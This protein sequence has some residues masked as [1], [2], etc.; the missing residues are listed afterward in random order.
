MPRDRNC[1][2]VWACDAPKA[3]Q[4]TGV[5]QTSPSREQAMSCVIADSLTL[6]AARVNPYKG[7]SVQPRAPQM[8]CVPSI[9]RAARPRIPGGLANA[10]ADCSEG[11][12]SHQSDVRF[13]QPHFLLRPQCLGCRQAST[14]SP[15]GESLVDVIL[16]ETESS[17]VH[18]GTLA[19]SP[20]ERRV[21]PSSS[22]TR[23]YQ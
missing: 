3:L 9:A 23:C 17:I 14:Q 19:D 5:L 11:R 22:H 4:V 8:P 7:T 1:L 10:R 15:V 12:L 20:E 2:N 6:E 16:D 13:H 18:A 21:S